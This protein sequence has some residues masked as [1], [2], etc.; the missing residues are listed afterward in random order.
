[1]MIVQNAIAETIFVH[2]R[3]GSDTNPGTEE[4]PVR[5]MKRAAEMANAGEGA[6]PTTIKIAPGTYSLTES[7]DFDSTRQYTKKERLVIEAT[8]LPDEPRWRPG[9][10]PTILSVE[11]PRT[12]SDLAGLTATHGMKIGV[13]HVTIRGLKFL[14][15]PL[16]RNWH[17]CVARTGNDLDDLVVTQCVFAGDADVM[18]IN[19]AVLATGGGFVV[20]HCIFRNCNAGAV[21]WDGPQGVIGKGCSMRYCIVDGARISGVWTCQT[22]EDFE[23]HHNIVTRSEYF[24]MRKRI[25]D[26]RRYRIRD[27]VVA[28][29]KN[30]SG[31]G[32]E[33]G[34]TG[35][36]G[37]EVIYEETNISKK[38]LVVFVKDKRKRNYLHVLPGTLG[39]GLG[40]GLFTE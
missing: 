35:L 1:M 13:S 34:P 22:A 15:N 3:N 9:M 28:G 24:W 2:G 23:F 27:C 18:D 19:C 17:L 30:H 38:G 25:A 40:A 8:V 10:M 37:P 6:G 36:T 21:F 32:V 11:D 29:N 16:L 31:Y 26:P 7:L 5:T 12:E 39:S 14:G 20:D 4:K 33:S